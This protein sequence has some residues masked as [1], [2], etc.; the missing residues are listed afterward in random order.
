VLESH[1][2]E[3]VVKVYGVLPSLTNSPLAPLD[4]PRV[5]RLAGPRVRTGNVVSFRLTNRGKGWRNPTRCGYLVVVASEESLLKLKVPSP[6]LVDQGVEILVLTT[7]DELVGPFKCRSERHSNQ[8]QLY[9]GLESKQRYDAT[10][11]DFRGRFYKLADV[12]CFI[13]EFGVQAEKSVPDRQRV[14]VRKPNEE[15]KVS[16][17]EPQKQ[18]PPLQ[19]KKQIPKEEKRQPRFQLRIQR[20]T[21]KPERSNELQARSQHRLVK[22]KEKE[23][24]HA[25]NVLKGRTKQVQALYEQ[26]G[27]LEQRLADA[28]NAVL[29]CEPKEEEPAHH[30]D[31][32]KYVTADL[33]PILQAAVPAVKL[34][35]AIALHALASASPISLVPSLDLIELYSISF[36]RRAEVKL[37]EPSPHWLSFQDAWRD[38][39]EALWTLSTENPNRLVLGCFPLLNRSLIEY[40]AQP[41]WLLAEDLVTEIHDGVVWPAN[42]RLFATV[43][44]SERGEPLPSHLIDSS[45][46]LPLFEVPE[47]NGDKPATQ[48]RNSIEPISLWP[49]RC[50]G[51]KEHRARN[52]RNV[53]QRIFGPAEE[54]RVNR[55]TEV[56]CN[57][58]PKQYRSPS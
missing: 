7:E 23:L 6:V 3:T 57:E 12:N 29:D 40:W 52:L 36:S 54:D 27:V 13:G 55:M 30:P 53:F 22:E 17:K 56:V 15:K 28:Q 34:G 37:I 49:A 11:P 5:L 19:K 51:P 9:A 26:I 44:F 21:E 31:E 45:F 39:L 10:L 42:L 35:Q 32:F 25:E 38:S 8:I 14:R 43:D 58:W 2:A 33:L 24:A 16:E 50:T 18:T 1:A 20:E 48:V 41:L 4:A 46:S 47:N